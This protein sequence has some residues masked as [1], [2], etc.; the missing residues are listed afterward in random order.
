MSERVSV[1]VTAR[2]AEKTIQ[3]SVKSALLALEENDEVI[4][5]LDQ[6][7]DD[8]EGR[9]DAI[10]DRRV[11][12]VVSDTH[13]GI[14]QSRNVLLDHSTNEYVAV[15]D[16]DDVCLPW[17][18]LISRRRLGFND[19]LFGTAFVFGS[20]LRPL[21]LLPQY[22]I[23][24]SPRQVEL[25]L[26]LGNP[27]VHSTMFARRVAIQDVGGYADSPSEDYDLWLRMVVAGM[28]LRRLATPLVLYRFHAN[29]ASQVEGFYGAVSSNSS[30]REL[31]SEAVRL[32]A[33]N[34]GIAGQDSIDIEAELR[35]TLYGTRPMMRL[36]HAG[37]PEPLKQWKNRKK[38]K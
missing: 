33:R 5:M 19:V 27:L 14:T 22:P 9:L 20:Q 32:A 16:A 30:L 35:S 15:L 29:Q 31:K 7:S 2:N 34:S 36:E 28:S 37:L 38:T 23:S 17:R 25:A 18:F 4:V 3:S 26:C 1:L 21:P 24:L 10:R 11:R 13:R 6:C 12:K 8:T